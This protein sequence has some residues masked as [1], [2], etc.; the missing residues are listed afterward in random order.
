MTYEP[1]SID[2][3][4]GALVIHDADAKEAFMLMRVVGRTRDGR[5][6]TRYAYKQ[7][8]SCGW[9]R[10]VW[11]NPKERLLD[12]ARFGIGRE[13]GNAEMLKS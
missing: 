8:R 10:K 5:L 7:P 4:V 3:P 6:K 11:V 9:S 13:S 12:P 1:N 2:W